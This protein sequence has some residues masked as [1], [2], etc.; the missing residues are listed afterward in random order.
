M[1]SLSNAPTQTSAAEVAQEVLR[2]ESAALSHLADALPPD[3]ADVVTLIADCTGQ[4]KGR[5]IVSGMGKSGHIGAKIAATLASTGTPAQFVHPGEASHGD[6]GMITPHDVCLLLSNSGETAELKDI[7]GHCLRFKVPLVALT[8]N[9]DS[10]IARAAS[11]RL[12]LPKL[13]EACGIGM[14]PTTSTTLT[15]AMGDALAVALLRGRAFTAEDFAVFHP[16]GKLGAQMAKVADLMHVGAEIPL[17]GATT[18]MTE[19]LLEMT[20]KGFGITGVTE[21]ARLVG[22]VT[23]GDL[24]RNMGDLMGQTAGQVAT[25]DPVTISPGTL[26]AAALAEMQARKI[27]VLMVTEGATPVGILHIHDLLR[28][29]VV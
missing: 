28:A 9:P 26:A 20:S 14:V 7:L 10:T 23:D 21:D 17:V 4:M 1:T 6:L 27:S 11:Y 12:T 18:P 15:L 25:P 29:G 3:F 5:V 2:T 16:G 24:R 13:A 8:S 19:A 22:V